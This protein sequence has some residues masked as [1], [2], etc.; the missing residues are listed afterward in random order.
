M[1]KALIDMPV[2]L[3]STVLEFLFSVMISVCGEIINYRF[4]SKLK[5]D[6]RRTPLGRKGNVIE[7]IMR[8]YC[9]LQMIYWPYHLLT[10]WV[11]FNEIIPFE[12]MNGWWCSAWWG[13]LKFGRMCI[14]WN[15]LF[16]ALIRYIYIVH[17]QK[18]N[19]W[20][21]EKIGRYFR[22][23]SIAIPVAIETIGLFVTTSAEYQTTFERDV[24]KSCVVSLQDH[25]TT[26][27]IQTPEPFF[28]ALTLQVIPE[29]LILG[30]YSVYVC[31]TIAVFSNVIDGFLY[32]Q[33]H[34]TIKRYMG[35]H[36]LKLRTINLI[37][38]STYIILYLNK[39]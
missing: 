8:W 10:F 36:I 30:V 6:K 9:K 14:G 11:L 25:N 27:N 31:L 39:K 13:V 33:I 22:I 20:N 5:E 21:F 17:R 34:R 7:P 15:S 3:W 24:F 2:S 23:S 12:Y 35:K 29:W 37:K 18:S 38:K 1:W 28:R 4:M 19:Q 32:F 26:H 16:V